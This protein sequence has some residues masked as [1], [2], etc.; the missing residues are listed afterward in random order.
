MADYETSA[1]V[2]ASGT[3]DLTFRSPNSRYLARVTQVSAVGRN[4][5]G[6]ASGEILRDNRFICAFVPTGDSAAGE[7]PID[8]WPG[9]E[10]QARW[11]GA[12]A[13]GTVEAMFIYDL[14]PTAT[15]AKV[16]S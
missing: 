3:V 1:T 5:G 2:P 6:A 8:V 4:I 7:P 14:I 12:A 9:Q 15:A 11:T 16:P 10:M 13:G